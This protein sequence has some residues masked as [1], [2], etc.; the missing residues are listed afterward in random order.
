[1]IMN[2][3]RL[4]FSSLCIE[5]KEMIFCS[6]LPLQPGTTDIVFRYVIVC[7]QLVILMMFTIGFIC[8]FYITVD[9][10]LASIKFILVIHCIKKTITCGQPGDI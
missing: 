2:G 5:K 9:H 7:S 10:D 3:F 6:I 8:C 4:L 1:M